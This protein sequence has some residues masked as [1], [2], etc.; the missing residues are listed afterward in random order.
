[1]M[2]NTNLNVMVELEIKEI[3]EIHHSEDIG[4][5]TKENDW[6][7]DQRQWTSFNVTFTNGNIMS[8]GSLNEI[9]LV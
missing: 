4:Q 9:N 1:M 5:S 2:V 8:F 3:K 6:W 7:P